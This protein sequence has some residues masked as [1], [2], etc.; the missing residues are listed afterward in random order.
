MENNKV[1][2]LLDNIFRSQDRIAGGLVEILKREIST[3]ELFGGKSHI[4]KAKETVVLIE[5]IREN[6]SLSEEEDKGLEKI[7]SLLQ[8]LLSNIK[9]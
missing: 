5:S 7:S 9:N 1:K 3:N 4:N 8:K 6:E 2:T